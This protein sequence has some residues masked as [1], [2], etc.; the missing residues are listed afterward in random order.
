M[1][2]MKLLDSQ[3]GKYL[4]LGKDWLYGGECVHLFTE[5]VEKFIEQKP[6]NDAIHNGFYADCMYIKAC[7]QTEPQGI[8]KTPCEV[9]GAV[10]YGSRYILF[11]PGECDD[12]NS[13]FEEYSKSLRGEENELNK[14]MELIK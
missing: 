7:F 12:Y 13:I 4:E 5:E 2:N 9:N 1:P 10:M 3:T 8:L 11:E 6:I 14:L